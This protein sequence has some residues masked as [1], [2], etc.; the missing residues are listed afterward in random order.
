M[1]KIYLEIFDKER[2][3]VFNKLVSFN[4]V[5]VLA[6]GTAIALQ[7]KHR[8]S[9]DLD[10]FTTSE[11]KDYLRQKVRKVLGYTS[12]IIKDSTNQI[13]VITP[14]EVKVTFAKHPYPPLNP[15]IRT[16]SINLFNLSDLAS[17]KAYTIGRRGTWRDYVDMFFL[18][19]EGY[20]SL[21]SV[22]KDA[23]KRFGTEFNQRLFLQQLLYTGD[24]EEFG[25]DFLR[26]EYKPSQII[27]YFKKSVKDFS[28][29]RYVV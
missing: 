28:K 17:N 26:K 25:I 27:D 11:I 7:I 19:K 24:L 21:D 23:E 1:S 18:L 10:I 5:G 16:D 12:Q 3:E 20:V 13:D 2:L 9:F 6:G 29:T 14:N 8:K 4:K 22:I 15:L